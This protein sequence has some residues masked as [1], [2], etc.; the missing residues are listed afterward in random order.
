MSTVQRTTLIKYHYV[1]TVLA[2]FY[3]SDDSLLPSPQLGLTASGN[4]YMV[5][6]KFV[7]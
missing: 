4:Y 6:I 3:E 2:F 7:M 5:A 1:R